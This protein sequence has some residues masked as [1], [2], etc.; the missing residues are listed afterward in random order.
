MRPT[1]LKVPF[2]SRL[3]EPW[4]NRHIKGVNPISAEKTRPGQHIRTNKY[5]HSF[6]HVKK[7]EAPPGPPRPPPRPPRPGPRGDM[8]DVWDFVRR[9][10]IQYRF[11]RNSCG[12]SYVGT[13]SAFSIT[14]ASFVVGVLLIPQRR[15]EDLAITRKSREWRQTFS[16]VFNQKPESVLIVCVENQHKRN[17]DP[18]HPQERTMKLMI[19]SYAGSP[20]LN[21]AVIEYSINEKR[22]VVTRTLIQT[23]HKKKLDWVTYEVWTAQKPISQIACPTRTIS[24]TQP[25]L[26][27]LSHHH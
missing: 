21:S 19:Q 18:P 25:I 9:I 23:W 26:H 27:Y 4:K 20:S 16:C 17:C 14:C 1:S 13:Y 2:P 24:P 8:I 10:S 11:H 22:V 12:R 15:W 6:T 5:T 3:N 7:I